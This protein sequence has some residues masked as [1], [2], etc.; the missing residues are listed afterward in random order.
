MP[1]K[2]EDERLTKWI[3]KSFEASRENYGTASIQRDLR[4]W[5][6]TVS[7]RRIGDLL[8]KT[9]WV[10]KTIKNFKVTIKSKQLLLIY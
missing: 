6:E 7:R 9:G 1:R 4:E 8:K 2:N 10:C 3:I 5:G